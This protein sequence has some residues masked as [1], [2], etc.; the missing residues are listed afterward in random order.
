MRFDR[1]SLAES[2]STIISLVDWEM[3]FDRNSVV[4]IDPHTGS[5]VDWE[6]RFDRND[7]EDWCVA[8]RV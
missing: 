8:S 1:N 3:R 5:L 7:A 2:E 4:I 6:M